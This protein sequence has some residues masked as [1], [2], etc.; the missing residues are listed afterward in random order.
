VDRELGLNM[1]PV[2]V[3]RT[4]RRMPGALVDWVRNASHESALEPALTSGEVAALA[5]QKAL[6]HLFDALIFNADRNASNWL[7]DHD[8]HRLYLIDHSRSFRVSGRVP[9][10]YLSKRVRLP[11]EVYENLVALSRSRLDALL[12]DV[13]EPGQIEALMSRR[14][15]LLEIIESACLEL[16]EEAVIKD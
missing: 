1:V 12:A 16:G 6:M 13:L 14:D 7:I 2:A 8:R 10:T 15:R 4:V 3:I 5:E 9:E 11:R